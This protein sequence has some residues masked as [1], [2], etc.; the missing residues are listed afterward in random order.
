MIIQLFGKNQ[1]NKIK[2]EEVYHYIIQ[3]INF[4]LPLEVWLP[5]DSAFAMVWNNKIGIGGYFYWDEF[6]KMI[7]E[8]LF[9]QNIL[10][11]NDIVT[12]VTFLLF[13]QL[14]ISYQE[15]LAY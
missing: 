15:I 11:P 3:N 5:I 14:N 1:S 8:S 6:T 7:Q 9:N 12:Q 2:S 10:I 13:R 4:E